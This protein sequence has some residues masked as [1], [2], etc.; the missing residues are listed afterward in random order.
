[1]ARLRRR[2][3]RAR[4]R[5]QRQAHRSGARGAEGAAGSQDRRLRGGPRRR[6]K[7]QRLHLAQGVLLG[8]LAADRPAAARASLRRSARMLPGLDAAS[9]SATR[10]AR[11]QRKARSCRRL[12]TRDPFAAPQ[13]D[14]AHEPRLSRPALPAPGLRPD[15]RGFARGLG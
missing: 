11:A 4:Q 13:A 8:P 5:A 3:R 15:V 12:P 1:M 14:G 9:H 2:D 6:H 10:A 7:L